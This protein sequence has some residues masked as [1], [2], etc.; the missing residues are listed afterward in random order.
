MSAKSTEA[1]EA[2]IVV[3]P[4]MTTAAALSADSAERSPVE[5][6]AL[7]ADLQDEFLADDLVPPTHSLCWTLARLRAWFEAGGVDEQYVDADGIEEQTACDVLVELHLSTRYEGL[8]HPL[9]S[10]YTYPR[11]RA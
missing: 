8:G 3:P 2:T 6:K 9:G 10:T 5:H 4:T 1:A 7:I 11:N